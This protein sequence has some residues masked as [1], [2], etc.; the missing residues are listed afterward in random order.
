MDL[1]FWLLVTL[2]ASASI[3]ILSNLQDLANGPKPRPARTPLSLGIGIVLG[4]I[5]LA[6]TILALV[7]A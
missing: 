4:G 2:A 6:L 7:G 5:L 3:G 1:A